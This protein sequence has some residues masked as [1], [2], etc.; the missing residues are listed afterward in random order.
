MSIA[1]INVSDNTGALGCC[2]GFFQSV[3]SA[4]V[5]QELNRMGHVRRYANGVT[6]VEEGAEPSVVG[7][8]TSGVVR[9]TQSLQDGRQ[10]VVGLAIAG[11]FFGHL[12]R[13]GD[14]FRYEAATDVSAC[15][16][17][18]KAFE[19]IMTR[20]HDL[21]HLVMTSL[22]GDLDMCREWMIVLGRQNTLERLV[23]FML[24]ISRRM[25]ASGLV[26]D[27]R[28]IEV[29]ITRRDIAA[30]LGTTVET[31]SRH[32]QTLARKRLIR[33]IDSSHFEVLNRGQLISLSGHDGI[34]GDLR[35]ERSRGE[36][37]RA[38]GSRF[39]N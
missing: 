32:V 5:R 12:F 9:I 17:R 1:A 36:G 23:S 16:F 35:D 15:V 13:R 22:L 27:P 33:I 28:I 7:F 3:A 39:P 29:P 26:L 2:S 4:T 24:H 11:D 21:E 19:A 6:L 34:S 37:E 31:I 18:Q 25:H 20:D 14:L 30:Y 8:V 10:Q 38:A